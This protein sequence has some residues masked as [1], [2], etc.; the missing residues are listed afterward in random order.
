MNPVLDALREDVTKAVEIEESALKLINGINDRIEKARQDAIKNGATEAELA[1]FAEL[2]A[3]LKSE[4]A[5]LAAA[6]EAN[7]GE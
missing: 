1:P 5:V 7:T 6:V 2:S 4:N 3:A